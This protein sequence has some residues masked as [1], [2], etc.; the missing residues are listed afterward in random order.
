MSDEPKYFDGN[1]Y[2]IKVFGSY[3]GYKLA[4]VNWKAV[5]AMDIA[6]APSNMMVIEKI[7]RGIAFISNNRHSQHQ[8]KEECIKWID[9]QTKEKNND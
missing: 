4:I 3:K 8:A 1:T 9:E 6:T 7:G 2:N 5:N